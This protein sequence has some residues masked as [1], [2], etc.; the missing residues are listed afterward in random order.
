[1]NCV[2]V[3]SVVA[4]G[5]VNFIQT[6]DSPPAASVA[7]VVVQRLDLAARR[8]DHP[9]LRIQ[10]H[11]VGVVREGLVGKDRHFEAVGDLQAKRGVATE[12]KKS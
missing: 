5:S 6:N 1:M 9:S 8:D 12:N 3:P 11:R 4:G 2:C 7:V 10:G